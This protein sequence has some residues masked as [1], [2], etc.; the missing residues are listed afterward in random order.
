M[1]LCVHIFTRNII[2]YMKVVVNVAVALVLF[3]EFCKL[4]K[5]AK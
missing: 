2:C 1:F 4:T 3:H 5:L